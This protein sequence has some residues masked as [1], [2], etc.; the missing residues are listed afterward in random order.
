MLLICRCFFQR[1]RA[2]PGVESFLNLR[3]TCSRTN[4]IY[5]NHDN[6]NISKT[7]VSRLY[8]MLNKYH[9]NKM[10]RISSPP[11]ISRNS[12]L[13]RH[14]TTLKPTVRVTKKKK[15]NIKPV[16]MMFNTNIIN[17]LYKTTPTCVYM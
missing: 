17:V 7:I 16:V 4:I 14:T 2:I 1:L 11:P 5:M 9:T 10:I 8:P 15:K 12:S 3:A 13:Y 6:V